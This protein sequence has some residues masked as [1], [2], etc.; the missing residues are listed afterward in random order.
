MT[1]LFRLAG[2]SALALSL[3]AFSL[4]TGWS[5]TQAAAQPAMGPGMMGGGA[6]RSAAP[7]AA[8]APTDTGKSPQAAPSAGWGDDDGPW[9]MRGWHGRGGGPGHGWMGPQMMGWGGYGPSF[10]MMRGGYG[11]HGGGPG[12]G[13]MGPR[14]MGWGGG[15][16]PSPWMMRGGYGYCAGIWGAGQEAAEALTVDQVKAR[17][18]LWLEAVG[19]RHVKLGSVTQKNADT[20]DATIVTTDTNGLVQRY[21]INSHTGQMRPAAD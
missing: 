15:Y 8:A 9:M 16:G 21:E 20:I 19:N 17:L 18:Q 10:W 7:P 2:T 1:T 5:G 11:P 4:P 3:T 13:W 6:A 14:M 12:D